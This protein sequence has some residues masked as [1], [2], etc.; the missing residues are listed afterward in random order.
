MFVCIS[1]ILGDGLY[2]FIKILFITLTNIYRERKKRTRENEFPVLS[3]NEKHLTI[4]YDEQRRNEMFMGDQIPL[5]VS[6][7]GY[8]LLAAISTGVLPQIFPPLK[9]YFVIVAYTFVPILGFCNAYGCGLTDW[10]MASTYGK[11]ALFIFASW[12]GKEDG[13]I[14]AGLAGCGV[15]MVIVSTASDLMQDFKTCYLTLSSPRSMFLSQVIGTAMGCVIGPIS[16]WLFYRAFDLGNQRGEYPA[17]Y[18]LIY[19]NLAILG[20][21]GFGALPKH[22]LT[23]C[24]CFFA[25]AIV[26]N[27]IRDRVPKRVSVYIPLPMAM[28]IPFYLGAYFAIDMCV[29][30]VIAFMWQ[31]LKYK[32]ADVMVPAMASGFI[33]GEGIW[34][35][36]AAI[37]ELAKVEPPIC[38]KFLSRQ[39]NVRVDGFIQG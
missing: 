31:R 20:V 21:Q 39:Q 9:W 33:C 12:A 14:L 23:L 2:N 13:G 3:G 16:F 34:T 32:S 7:S 24:Y 30:T 26:V 27:W 5:W 25:F 18:A 10:S 35:L 6:G 1:L 36:A 37:L 38:M 19:R 15:I 4:S 17:P 8:V 28:A 29:G 11:L 22:C